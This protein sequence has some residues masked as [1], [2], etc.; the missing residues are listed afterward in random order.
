MKYFLLL[1]VC[2][3][4]INGCGPCPDCGC[5]N[6]DDCLSKYKFEEARK[7]A[8][9][10]KDYEYSDD[11]IPEKTGTNPKGDAF[12]KIICSE[13]NYWINQNELNKAENVAKELITLYVELKDY[14]GKEI[15]KTYLELIHTIIIKHCEK[16]EYELAKQLA[17]G[18]TYS[19]DDDDLWIETKE[20]YNDIKKKLKSFQEIEPWHGND[21]YYKIIKYPRKEASQ[22]IEEYERGN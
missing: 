20:Y 17:N 1:I 8:S 13:T 7:Y 15:N 11:F 9:N 12:F 5:D 19:V 16:K 22:I 4:F 6:V 21:G 14:N 10:L 2:I 3:L 18:L